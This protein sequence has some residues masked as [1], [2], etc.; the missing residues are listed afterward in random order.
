VVTTNTEK[1]KPHLESYRQLL[2]IGV[3]TTSLRIIAVLLTFVCSVVLA[4]VLGPKGFGVYSYAFAIATLLAV[5]VQMGMPTLIFRETAKALTQE[6][7][8]RIKGLW[9]W[10]TSRVLVASIGISVLGLLFLWLGQNNFSHEI[11]KTMAISLGLIPFLALGSTR[12][13]A[14]RGLGFIVK[15]QLPETVVRPVF[16]LILLGLAFLVLN[17]QISPSEAM[18][19]QLLSVFIAFAF[20]AVLLARSRRHQIRQIKTVETDG[21]VWWGT[22][23]PFTLIAGLE[24]ILQRTDL[25]MIGYWLPVEQVGFYKIAVS[26]AAMTLFGL[27]VVGLTVG[28]QVIRYISNGQNQELAR[29]SSWCAVIALLFTAPVFLILAWWG[30]DVL[31]LIY[32]IEYSESYSPLLVLISAQVISAFFGIN[33]LIL[34]MSGF[35]RDSLRGVLISV[36]ANVILNAIFI[37]IYGMIGAAI[38]TVISTSILNIYTWNRVRKTVG[39]DSSA[40][41]IFRKPRTD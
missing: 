19:A 11:S 34:S 22:L 6:N 29:L 23:W 36:V 7:W 41:S 5:P 17:R 24:I 12:A 9:I 20:G 32:G 13:A 15:G 2:K 35:E 16:L 8:A 25:I 1:L 33:Q 18:L 30:E 31:V 28:H 27:R 38:A 14:L 37:P 39:I 26:I 3:G 4:R 40:L 21:D 10:S